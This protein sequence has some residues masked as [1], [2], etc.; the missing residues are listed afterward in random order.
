[1]ISIIISD[2]IIIKLDKKDQLQGKFF[3][4]WDYE[5]HNNQDVNFS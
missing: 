2:Q 3:D 1:M 4:L 5:I